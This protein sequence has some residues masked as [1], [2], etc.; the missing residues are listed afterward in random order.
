MLQL[1]RNA[2]SG[3]CYKVE[4]LLHRLARPVELIDV[5][6]GQP[7]S[8]AQR[9]A[10]K[11]LST[12]GRIPTLVLDD[13][14]VLTESNAI[15]CYLAEGTPYVPADAFDRAQVLRW[16]FFEQNLHEPHIATRRFV[17]TQGDPSKVSADL[18][19]IWLE[20]GT[21]ALGVMERH[22]SEHDWFGP[23]GYSIAD[24]ALYAYTH[25]ADQG[26]Y[27][28]APFPALRAWLE[29]F[30]AQPGHRAMG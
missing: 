29:R 6:F 5:T 2:I 8:E 20:R 23:A 24:I 18:L 11:S 19:E 1:H 30:A 4:L 28:L 9:A 3:N 21:D 10:V 17:M 7:E 15:L 16:M 27:D 26:G 25:V 12:I 13:G 14:R 22:L